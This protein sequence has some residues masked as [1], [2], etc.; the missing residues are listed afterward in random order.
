VISKVLILSVK[1]YIPSNYDMLGHMAFIEA[2]IK[3]GHIPLQG[4]IYASYY[5]IFSGQHIVMAFLSL[6][7]SAALPYVIK[8]YSVNSALLALLLAISLL[9]SGYH[10]HK[11]GNSCLLILYA[12]VIATIMPNF[13]DI[14]GTKLA[15][16]ILLTYLYTI[17]KLTIDKTWRS[18]G[19]AIII[20]TS[21]AVTH[22]VTA[23]YVLIVS[24]LFIGIR[25][26]RH[27]D[28]YSDGNWNYR[29]D[30]LSIMLPGITY[31]MMELY[32]KGFMIMDIVKD[33]LTKIFML[34]YDKQKVL[35][36][37]EY[38]AGFYTLSP[39]D[40][41]IIIALY[42][43]YSLTLLGLSLVAMLTIILKKNRNDFEIYSLTGFLVSAIFFVY[44]SYFSNLKVR[45]LYYAF[46]FLIF[47]LDNILNSL[48]G[49]IH[50]MFSNKSKK[51]NLVTWLILIPIFIV[52]LIGSEGLRIQELMPAYKENEYTKIYPVVIDETTELEH[53][54]ALN[55][56]MKLNQLNLPIKSNFPYIVY[57]SNPYETTYFTNL[58]AI[59]MKK[60]D[61]R[62]LFLFI[63]RKYYAKADFEW[64][65]CFRKT[66]DNDTM[67]LVFNAK[68]L[69]AGIVT[70]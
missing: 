60:L 66:Y 23:I 22:N 43:G 47:M 28:Y 57:Y 69:K 20:G 51:C 3:E 24:T 63:Q 6:V 44:I 7:T 5:G 36:I 8:I 62:N 31:L 30:T 2:L 26:I 70:G 49:F 12:L 38:Y 52:S 68:L 65:E 1:H 33:F 10:E 21:L 42:A 35:T 27:Y 11:K 67:S 15:I 32:I 41:V 9:Y 40:R 19:L 37:T 34:L 17:Y 56:L 55:S 58:C 14:T 13:A 54:V 64:R 25:K 50:R 46:P 48:I 4:V 16:A 53:I 59:R 61:R 45:F 39:S 18:R 29:V